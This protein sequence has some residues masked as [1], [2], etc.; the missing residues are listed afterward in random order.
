M[1]TR[2]RIRDL[3]ISTPNSLL[4]GNRSRYDDPIHI[5]RIYS[6]PAFDLSQAECVLPSTYLR[7]TLILHPAT[8]SQSRPVNLIVTGSRMLSKPCRYR[9]A[10]N[11]LSPS[12]LVVQVLAPSNPTQ[13]PHAPYTS[14][15]NHA[16][17]VPINSTVIESENRNTLSYN[18]L[19][20]GRAVNRTAGVYVREMVA[21]TLM[22]VNPPPIHDAPPKTRRIHPRSHMVIALRGRPSPATHARD[23]QLRPLQAS[24]ICTNWWN[25]KCGHQL[26]HTDD[27]QGPLEMCSPLGWGPRNMTVVRRFDATLVLHGVKLLSEEPSI[28]HMSAYTTNDLYGQYLTDHWAIILLAGYVTFKTRYCDRVQHYTCTHEQ[29]TTVADENPVLVHDLSIRNRLRPYKLLRAREEEEATPHTPQYRA[30]GDY[31]HNIRTFQHGSQCAATIGFITTG[32]WN[33]E[34]PLINPLRNLH[35]SRAGLQWQICTR[36]KTQLI[37]SKHVQI[38]PQWEAQS[39]NPGNCIANNSNGK[40]SAQIQ[41]ACTSYLHYSKPHVKSPLTT[42]STTKLRVLRLRPG[43]CRCT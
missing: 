7:Y 12:T 43:K 6:N 35:L 8:C 24:I 5:R 14:A 2:L 39:I 36:T 30:H 4:S 19:I 13:R 31:S 28:T 21:K 26:V 33:C 34:R 10:I 9:K 40:Q 11:S 22:L 37:V 1:G 15:T 42:S 20:P 23:C 17:S 16:D 27:G 18:Q 32:V 38:P 29:N 3:D 25:D 41:M